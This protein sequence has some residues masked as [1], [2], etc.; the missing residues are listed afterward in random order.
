MYPNI[1]DLTT[2][3]GTG[4]NTGSGALTVTTGGEMAIPLSLLGNPSSVEVLADINGSP[5]NFFS[6]QFLA[7][8]PNGI[9]NVG[10]GPYSSPSA[11]AFNFGSTPGEFFTVTSVPEPSTMVLGAAGMA[12]LLLLRRRR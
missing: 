1:Y 6:N 5:D 2:A 3:A 12:L 9:G 4:V 10:G 7:G 11:G 8:L